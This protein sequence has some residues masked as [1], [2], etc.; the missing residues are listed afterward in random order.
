M[1]ARFSHVCCPIV[2]GAQIVLSGAYLH[3]SVLRTMNGTHLTGVQ[4]I[5]ICL[6]IV[7]MSHALLFLS[8]YIGHLRLHNIC[9]RKY[10]RNAKK[11]SKR[12]KNY[13][14]CEHLIYIFVCKTRVIG[15]DLTRCRIVSLAHDCYSLIKRLFANR[16]VNFN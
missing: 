13:I 16:M 3:R 5:N 8:I 11:D 6:C 10:L 9:N 12:S 4:M 14:R 1:A 15:G 2:S 7:H